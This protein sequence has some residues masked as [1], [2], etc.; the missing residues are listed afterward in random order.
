MQEMAGE[1]GKHEMGEGGKQGEQKGEDEK[2]EGAGKREPS[3]PHTDKPG[4]KPHKH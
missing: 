2:R 4:T 1:M 3:K